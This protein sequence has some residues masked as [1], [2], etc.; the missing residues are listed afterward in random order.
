MVVI[1]TLRALDPGNPGIYGVVRSMTRLSISLDR[2]IP[3]RDVLDG[4]AAPLNSWETC[5]ICSIPPFELRPIYRPLSRGRYFQLASQ[6][7]RYLRHD[8]PPEGVRNIRRAIDHVA[9][10]RRVRVNESQA[11]TGAVRFALD[12]GQDYVISRLHGQSCRGLN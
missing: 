1:A 6:V 12:D 5:S 3:E 11:C 7:V 9:P 2:A 4:I 10:T 8:R